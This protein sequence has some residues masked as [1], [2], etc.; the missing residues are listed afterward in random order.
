M[1]KREINSIIYK[2]L[3]R[4]FFLLSLTF[5]VIL[6]SNSGTYAQ[7]EEEL[8]ESIGDELEAEEEKEKK[9]KEKEEK[10]EDLK[11]DADKALDKEKFD[12]A[13][14][15]YKQMQE[16]FPDRDYANRQL[17]LVEQKKEQLR[18]AKLDEQYNEIVAEADK[19]RDKEKWD[20]AISKYQE[21]IKLKP[22]D[23]SAK[24]GL[25]QAKK[26]KEAAAERK[27]KEALNEKYNNIIQEA[28]DLL[29]NS[30]WDQA[31]SKYQEASKVKPGEQLPKDKIA[32]AEKLKKEEAERKKQQAI[33]EKFDKIIGEANDFLSNK[34]W[35]KAISKYQEASK[36]KPDEQLP[37]DKIAEAE[38]LKKE[39]AEREKQQALTEK[40]NKIIQE[41][42]KLLG[43]KMWDEAV[44]KYEEAAEVKPDEDYP[45]SQIQK[46]KNLKQ[47]EK[48]KEKQAE[49]DAQY[50]KAVK[51]ADRLMGEEQYKKA[52]SKY[53]EAKAIKESESYPDEQITKANEAIAAK[54]KAAE[55]AA[56][57]EEYDGLIK[58]ADELMSAEKWQDAIAKYKEAGS[59]L[60]DKD[61]PNQQ[62]TKANEAI[63]A[64]QKQEEK[65]A[66]FD[67]MLT[68]AQAKIDNEEW[69]SAL[70]K[71]NEAGSLFP[72]SERLKNMKSQAESGLKK[73]Q[74]LEKQKAKEER[75]QAALENQYNELIEKG[76]KALDEKDW[77]NAS[78]NYKQAADLLPEKEYPKNQLQ[79]V[80][81]LKKEEAAKKQAAKEEA[82]KQAAELEDRYNGLLT[83]GE[84]AME[85]KEWEAAKSYFKQAAELKPSAEVPT[86][87]IEEVNNKIKMAEAEAERQAEKEKEKEELKQQF[88]DIISQGDE[89]LENGEFS[90]SIGLYN[91]ADNLMP[92]NDVVAGKIESAK[93]AMKE[94]EEAAKQRKKEEEKRLEERDQEFSSL[95]IKGEQ[96]ILDKDW[97]QAKSFFRQAQSLKP[98]SS[99][100]KERI[101]EVERMIEMEEAEKRKQQAEQRQKEKRKE[102]YNALVQQAD[103][104]LQNENW[105]TAK[106]LYKQ[107]VDMNNE[108]N[109][110]QNQ[111]DKIDDLKREAEKRA[112]EQAKDDKYSNFISKG[113]EAMQSEKYG[114]AVSNYQQALSVKANDP[115]AQ[116]KLATARAKRDQAAEDAKK[117]AAEKQ[118]EELARK[119][120]EREKQEKEREARLQRI[121]E[122][123]PEYLAENYPSGYS[124]ETIDQGYRQVEKSVIVE[125][126]KGRKLIRLV[127]PWGQEFYY[128]NGKRVNGD[129]YNQN[130]RPYVD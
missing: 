93:Q 95:M 82:E 55:Q 41:A 49:I 1:I 35:D 83:E 129:V 124:H 43:N 69:Q 4:S 6:L 114:V 106:S 51:E 44:A 33:N 94:A 36:V 3:L 10:Y 120:A 81:E 116:E 113:N 72:E 128:L 99:G 60:P 29:S 14:N 90:Q 101:A 74:E 77:A 92:D 64:D 115:V 20:E 52:I 57:Q 86:K 40:Y 111:L 130:V 98:A 54:E 84:N 78:A 118:K 121:K 17:R 32:E 80:E 70:D 75:Q 27:R 38:K 62:I 67:Q 119:K 85:R 45:N 48:E 123:S 97:T 112:A 16:L 76:D 127:Y 12:E 18:L 39:Q 68:D 11:S 47:E 125:D 73:Q 56:K 58:Q 23:S 19:L 30:Q 91:K 53:E 126:G 102:K 24:S 46:A 110:P 7:S 26:A 122:N 65:K 5:S 104:A 22:D 63:A 61:Y 100:P 15:L 79:K 96:A 107:A 108:D 71:L 117:R 105:A 50:Q 109:Y 2:V 87:K 25:E 31:I 8:L 89:A 42:D 13:T 66:Q 59:V 9:L 88:D 28:N 103:E 21:A 34:Q 37:K